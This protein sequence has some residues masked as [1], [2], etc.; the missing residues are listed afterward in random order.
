MLYVIYSKKNNM[1]SLTK[2]HLLG[3]VFF[4]E[5]YNTF[6]TFTYKNVQMYSLQFTFCNGN[7]S[8]S[9]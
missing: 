2:P 9:Q 1:A 3:L 4:V 7:Y 5:Q 6:S 8:F